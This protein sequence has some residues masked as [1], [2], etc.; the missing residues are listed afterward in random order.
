M[1]GTVLPLRNLFL[2]VIES[3]MMGF[4]YKWYSRLSIVTSELYVN[5][6]L[7]EFEYSHFFV[8]CIF[9]LPIFYARKQLLLSAR[10]SHRNSVR[11]FGRPSHGWI[12]QKR[13]IKSSPSIAWK[14]LVLGT[15][16]K[17]HKFKGDHSE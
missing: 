7:T 10:F 3:W 16:K 4:R 1:H 13:I 11:P 17:F 14:T 2:F 6:M 8:V 5:H 15:V 9:Y 12:S